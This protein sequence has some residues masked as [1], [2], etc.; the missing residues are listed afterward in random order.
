VEAQEVSRTYAYVCLYIAILPA[1][2]RYGI[3]NGLVCTAWELTR[4]RH[5][6]S[7]RFGKDTRLCYSTC[8]ERAKRR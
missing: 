5:P 4:Q 3:P 6:F 2:S 1:P 8:R 7:I